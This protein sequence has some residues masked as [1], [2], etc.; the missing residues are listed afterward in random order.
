MLD[1]GVRDVQLIVR[2]AQ[3][4]VRDVDIEPDPEKEEDDE[5]VGWVMGAARRLGLRVFLMPTVHVRE[6]AK[7]SWRGA[8]APR[9][10]GRWWA[11]YRRFI[12]HY[13]DLAEAHGAGLFAVGSE[14]V[15]TQIQESRWRALIEAVRARYRGQLT[16]SANWDRF[17]KVRIWDALDVAGINA[18]VPLSRV[19]DPSESELTQGWYAFKEKVLRWARNNEGKR[20]IFTEVG[21]PSNPFAAI[22]PY[23]YSLRGH[24]DEG[25]QLKCYRALYRSWQDVEG[26]AGIYFWNWFGE[27]GATD[28]GYTPRGKPAFEVIRHWYRGSLRPE[29]QQGRQR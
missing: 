24:P 17:E 28:R 27:G 13:A 1:A 20:F 16:Y 3:D 25:L 10:W 11:A 14:L 15:S 29:R 21:Y 6:D 19:R 23:D 18:Y 9:D 7:G 12:L 22:R 26:L 4:T 8:I 2:W 5:T